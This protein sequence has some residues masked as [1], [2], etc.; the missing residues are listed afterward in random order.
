MKQGSFAMHVQQD[1][2]APLIQLVRAG[3]CLASMT[4]HFPYGINRE[5]GSWAK[6]AMFE[7]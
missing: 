2:T 7:R 3:S 5:R 6:H 4:C 1:E